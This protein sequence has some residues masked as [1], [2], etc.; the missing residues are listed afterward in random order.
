MSFSDP[1]RLLLR[2]PQAGGDKRA[3]D[4]F[5][6][7][8]LSSAAARFGSL[9]ITL[10]S[11]YTTCSQRMVLSESH[12]TTAWLMSEIFKDFYFTSL[13]HLTVDIL[14]DC[15][16]Y[17]YHLYFNPPSLPSCR[18]HFVVLHLF[19]CVLAIMYAIIFNRSINYFRPSLRTLVQII[20]FFF[21]PPF[22]SF[23][24]SCYLLILTLQ[25]TKKRGHSIYLLYP[26]DYFDYTSFTPASLIL[27]S[28]LLQKEFLPSH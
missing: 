21:F 17:L 11:Q 3:A 12:R 14:P 13:F 15:A 16:K 25:E 27:F 28:F 6:S 22:I 19:Q 24:F 4:R 5:A 8:S 20:F 1:T 2:Q 23:S 10:Q 26:M 18:W 7:K 9:W